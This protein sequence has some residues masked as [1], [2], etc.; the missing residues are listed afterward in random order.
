MKTLKSI[1]VLFMGL[2]S[3]GLLSAQNN[4]ITGKILDAT[5]KTP[6]EF[7][8][9]ILLK[10]DS[11]FVTGTTSGLDGN[12]E[13]KYDMDED[14]LLSASYLGYTTTYM[15]VNSPYNG[16]SINILLGQSTVRLN[17][18]TI[19]AHSVI[20]KDD[21]K[22]IVPSEEQ[23]R[24]SIDG[25]DMIRKMQLPRLMVD[26]MSGEITM[27][28]NQIVQ[29][30]KNGV[31]VTNA[32]IASIPPADILRIEYLDDPG[33]RYGNVTVVINYITKKH[34]SGGNINGVL[35]NGAGEK[36]SSADDRLS[37]KYNDGKSE[38]S[39]NGVFVQRKG[40]WTREYDEWLI[41]PTSE[42]HRLE[43]GEPTLFNKKTFTGNLNYSLTDKNYFFNAQL[44]YRLNDFPNAFTDRKSTL[45][46]SD[47]TQPRSIIDHTV[48]K[49][50]SPSL[51]LYY[52]HNLKNDQLLIFNVVGTYIDT[53]SKR[54]YLETNENIIDTDIYSQIT[55]DKYSI[56]AEG[57]YEKKF[58]SNKITG[59]IKHSQSYTDNNYEGNTIA[60]ISMNQ[61][62]TNIYVE[63]QGKTGKWG[64]MANL[65]ASRIYYNQE[66]NS[67]EKYALQ[68]SARI[69]FEP[70]NDSYLRYRVN[71]RTNAP[72]L[73]A[74]NDVEQPLDQWTVL[75]GNPNLKSFQTLNQSLSAGYNK[76]IWGT[77]I[78]I[79][80][81]YEFDPI[82]ES[83]F[84][85]N[86]RFIHIEENQ[87]SFQN[88]S[89]ELTF[90]IKP[91]KD[92]LSLSITPRINRFISEGNHYLHTYTMSELRVNLDF[93]YNKWIANFTTITPPRF[94]YGEH[95][96]KSD[97]MYTIMAGYKM[98]KWSLMIGWL[99]PFLKEYKTDNENWAA[100]NPVKSQIHTTNTQSFLVKLAVNLNY[101]KQIRGGNKRTNNTDTDSGIMQGTKN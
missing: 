99:N 10:Q 38:W 4:I 94:M 13:I 22:V 43:I 90:R 85:E 97:Q 44:S 74:M 62:E 15:P 70:N 51:D 25:V 77:D 81:D 27:S 87:K 29:L 100:L 7:A 17:E 11:S 18:V 21:R 16:Q 41:F 67:T 84:Y 33:A 9:V 86:N 88:L 64:Y 1:F 32:E 66:N 6:V 96:T 89:A 72:S 39:A 35:Y 69:T 14:Y 42:L 3:I 59:G 48:E 78:T 95:V 53:D 98:P 63:Y 28:G 37:L 68:P 55:G 58:G 101:G 54:N 5:D 8:N 45:Y 93:S 80:Y 92:H 56:I 57:I 73:A 83:V 60:D 50:H 65:T 31:Q 75:R 26:P 82:M 36:R 20:V 61:A 24:T 30:R 49:I 71:L 52:Q 23:I 47:I 76:G 19:K 34:E 46:E 79:S 91:W 12:F 40:Y 2:L